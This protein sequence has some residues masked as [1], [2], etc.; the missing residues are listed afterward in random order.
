[1]LW[2]SPAGGGDNVSQLCNRYESP[3]WSFLARDLVLMA[4][5]LLMSPALNYRAYS[6]WSLA[7]YP[8]FSSS[9]VLSSSLATKEHTCL[10][11]FLK[12][13]LLHVYLYTLLFDVLKSG[14]CTNDVDNN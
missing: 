11:P 9:K 2:A 3:D 6:Y 7:T 13:I 5:L 8:F 12:C 1:M 10:S 14:K 4:Y